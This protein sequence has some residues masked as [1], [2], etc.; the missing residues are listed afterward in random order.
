MSKNI[1]Y[2]LLHNNAAIMCDA[3]CATDNWNRRGKQER[4][5]KMKAPKIRKMN[6]SRTRRPTARQAYNE[7]AEAV[8]AVFV[9]EHGLGTEV[10]ENIEDYL[11]CLDMAKGADKDAL[12]AAANEFFHKIGVLENARNVALNEETEY[13]EVHYNEY[14]GKYFVLFNHSCVIE[15]RAAGATLCS[16]VREFGEEQRRQLAEE[17]GDE[18]VDDEPSPE[19]VMAFVADA[20]KSGEFRSKSG[21]GYFVLKGEFYDA[22]EA[23]RK[24]TEYRDL[25]PH[26]LSHSIGIKT[27]K[28]QRGYGHAGQ[29]PKQMRFEVK[30]V[31]L[32]DAS[33]RECDP[34]DI[35]SGFLATTIAIHLGKRIG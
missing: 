10:M 16:T 34:F 17:E 26:N 7:M 28:L 30:S 21:E 1:C 12:M 9:G 14:S 4:N 11:Y 18:P 19:Q 23:G 24:T 31:R 20:I 22:I 3:N 33:D 29:P 25:S 2:N 15:A 13:C 6:A 8:A 27:V 35:P 5:G 32:M